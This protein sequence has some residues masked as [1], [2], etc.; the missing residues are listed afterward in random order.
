MTK[1]CVSYTLFTRIFP[2]KVFTQLVLQI[3]EPLILG[4]SSESSLYTYFQITA[5]LENISRSI[6]CSFSNI[7]QRSVSSWNTCNLYQSL[8]TLTHFFIRAPLD[9]GLNSLK[10]HLATWK[11]QIDPRNSLSGAWYPYE[12]YLW[13]LEK[14]SNT[15]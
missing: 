2:K 5:S 8:Q 9:F 14:W 12:R 1:I 6:F 3:D 7:V 10:E 13:W 11:F 15:L 4:C